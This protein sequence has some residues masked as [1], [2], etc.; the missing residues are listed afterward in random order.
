LRGRKHWR[1]RQ[2]CDGNVVAVEDTE[3]GGRV[4]FFFCCRGGSVIKTFTIQEWT[5]LMGDEKKVKAVATSTADADFLT[6][7]GGFT[8]PIVATETP[9]CRIKIP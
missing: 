5:Y 3:Y 7:H 1:K 8:I 2:T 9:V 4:P 6:V